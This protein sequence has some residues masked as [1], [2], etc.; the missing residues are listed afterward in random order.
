MDTNVL[1]C[2]TETDSQ[3]ENLIVTKGAGCGE[4]GVDRRFGM[5][6]F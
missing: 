3:T 2:R 4:S 6:V 5:E 1:I